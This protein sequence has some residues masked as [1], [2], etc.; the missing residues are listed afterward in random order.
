MVE[1]GNFLKSSRK[2]LEGAIQHPEVVDDYLRT[3]V[4]LN[5]VAGPY[6]KSQGPSVHISR[7]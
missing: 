1:T 7:F 4:S 2:N 5:R 3:K 6:K